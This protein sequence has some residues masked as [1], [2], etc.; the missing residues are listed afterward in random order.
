M[1]MRGLRVRILFVSNCKVKTHKSDNYDTK[2][3]YKAFEQN[4][5]LLVIQFAFEQWLNHEY[6]GILNNCLGVSW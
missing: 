5:F 3:I 4:M 2:M 1:K 6:I